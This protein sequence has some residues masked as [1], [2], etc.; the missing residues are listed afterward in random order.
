LQSAKHGDWLRS[1]E[2]GALECSGGGAGVPPALPDWAN[3]CAPPMPP[4]QPPA[5]AIPNAAR[6]VGAAPPTAREQHRTIA[7]LRALCCP[8][9]FECVRTSD[10][11]F[12]EYRRTLSN[13]LEQFRTRNRLARSQHQP[14]AGITGMR[15]ITSRLR[16]SRRSDRSSDAAPMFQESAHPAPCSTW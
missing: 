1:P 6:S 12:V 11:E 3:P 14:T 5:G 7:R 10:R 8:S 2:S 13:L 16:K 9:M 15:A 4:T